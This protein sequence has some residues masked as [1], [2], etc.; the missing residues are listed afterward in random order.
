MSVSRIGATRAAESIDDDDNDNDHD[1]DIR[2]RAQCR[3]AKGMD[4]EGQ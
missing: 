4:A 3:G 1:H 2:Q